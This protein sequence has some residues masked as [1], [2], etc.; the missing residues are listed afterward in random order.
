MWRYKVFKSKR[1]FPSFDGD[2]VYK[3][4][5]KFNQY[6]EI[7]EIPNGNKHKLTTYYL[8]GKALYW[9]QNC[10]SI[11]NVVVIWNN[12]VE[13]LYCRFGGQKDLL[14]ELKDLKHEGDLEIYIQDFNML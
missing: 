14:E 2:D 11:E 6:F 1:D 12:Y 9:H 8:E 4:L 10:T 3:C 13:P 7:E 5:Y